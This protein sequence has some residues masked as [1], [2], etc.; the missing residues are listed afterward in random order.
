[1]T[2][3]VDLYPGTHVEWASVQQPSSPLAS[4]AARRHGGAEARIGGCSETRRA[5]IANDAGSGCGMVAE[6]TKG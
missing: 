2:T 5:G 6:T 1:V 3:S 4:R